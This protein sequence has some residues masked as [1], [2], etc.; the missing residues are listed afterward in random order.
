M[1]DDF[2]FSFNTNNATKD[3]DPFG[4][5]LPPAP[6]AAAAKA[7]PSKASASEDAFTPVVRFAPS[8][9]K[10]L[11]ALSAAPSSSFMAMATSAKPKK[12]RATPLKATAA[13]AAAAAA[14]TATTTTKGKKTSTSVVATK[15]SNVAG[16]VI[17]RKAAAPVAVAKPE[18]DEDDDDEDDGL[19]A[20]QAHK[21]AKKA[22][23][24]KKTAD[25]GFQVVR[26][27]EDGNFDV[28]GGSEAVG[29]GEAEAEVE[30]GPS[31]KKHRSLTLKE[32]PHQYHA[33]PSD[34]ARHEAPSSSSSS[35]GK[36]RSK[37]GETERRPI[38]A[39]ATTI[40]HK[41]RFSEVE[42]LHPRLTQVLEAPLSEGGMALDATTKVQSSI[43][44]LLIKAR[45]AEEETEEGGE[46]EDEEGEKKKRA[47]KKSKEVAAVG[48]PRSVLMKSQTGSG[49]TLAFLLP[50]IHDLMSMQ[51]VPA[52][53]GGTRALVLSPTREL[54][55]QICQVAER[56]TNKCACGLVT[57]T[58]TGGERRKA[59]KARLRKGVVILTA[60]PGRLLDHL[61]STEAFTLSSLRWVVLDEAD[62]LLD[63]G[64]EKAI[65][66]ILGIL[67]GETLDVS[68]SS[69]AKAAAASYHAKPLLGLE[70]RYRA[71]VATHAKI[72][73]DIGGVCY[74]MASA[75]L[76]QAVCR[77]VKPVMGSASAAATKK[78]ARALKKRK[79]AEAKGE[80]VDAATAA[81]LADDENAFYLVD[82]ERE[83]ARLMAPDDVDS[84]LST[85]NNDGSVSMPMDW[86]S[87]GPMGGAMEA[88]AAGGSA[89]GKK[90][91]KGTS[92]VTGEHVAAPATLVQYTMTVS[93]K[94]RLAALT[95]F[96][97]A[98]A[99]DRSKVMVFMST[100]DSVD[101]HSLLF[102]ETVW[103]LEM[104]P[105]PRDGVD[106][107]K[108]KEED[109]AVGTGASAASGGKKSVGK[110]EAALS[111]ANNPKSSAALK[112]EEIESLEPLDICAS[113]GIL[114]DG[115]PIYRLHGSVPQAM[116]AK[117][118]KEFT[119]ASD[120]VLICTDVAA[121]G[122]DLPR[123]DW[124]V[125]YD[126]PCETSDYIH[127]AGRT[128][129]SGHG[130]SALL[131]LL[132]S[133]ASFAT[134]LH[135]HGMNTHAMRLDDLFAEVAPDIPG[136][137]TFKNSAEMAA[138]ILQRR[139]EV[140][141][142]RNRTLIGC[143]RQA[144]RSFV[145]AYATHSSDT[146]GI[147]KVH[148][149]HLGHV[150][151][152]FALGESPANLH[153]QS[154][155][156]TLGKVAN[157]YFSNT[158]AQERADA[159]RRARQDKF[160]VSRSI[161]GGG[162]ADSGRG[163]DSRGD[164]DRDRGGRGGGGRGGG[165]GG[166]GGGGGGRGGGGGGDGK[167]HSAWGLSDGDGG[168][169]PKHDRVKLRAMGGKRGGPAQRGAPSASGNFRKSDGGYFKKKLRTQTNSEFAA[170]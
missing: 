167:T 36:G 42:G 69:N 46:A 131:F 76:S 75:T 66:E 60:T 134:L 25:P 109:G 27:A 128:A 24:A 158:R 117:T 152:N 161:G 13:A 119:E 21:A 145:R 163:G 85:Q 51:P 89:G 40:F 88:V 77:L 48:V 70:K 91:G 53:D 35:A 62:R 136:A 2:D 73:K 44:P 113:N 155:D 110:I 90:G 87:D 151:K 52:R 18:E 3:E 56:L 168:R 148:S 11:A 112:R 107:K 132:P 34:L 68:A 99:K 6:T 154:A 149:L 102:R 12:V 122:L 118:I 74:I 50:I 45:K 170:S 97:R 59:E 64:F 14:A 37:G 65:L 96:L 81:A 121:R 101:Y 72:S 129:R 49:K 41:Q 39:L 137:Q 33:K 140:T 9:S 165:R 71:Q 19:D 160:A 4:L 135:S 61:R 147:F 125:Q 156:D 139:Y 108:D 104:D 31:K 55:T 115:V 133:E 30:A 93:A 10:S 94:W 83:T 5:G 169:Q 43:L 58:V 16:K 162:G 29:G 38:G 127:R 57:G 20:F 95:C 8:A 47:H 80:S 98:K 82:A 78:R 159:R 54:C 17:K 138:V 123:V 105:N 22:A 157:G 141:A 111:A 142:L 7:P 120:G 67:R 15:A 114:G 130:G 144:F 92:L 150:A 79:L 143:A 23:R 100:C 146:K 106:Q 84:L 26:E 126:P 32:D 124:I 116:R 86:A 1:E 28:V 63:M 164:R 153:E 166:G 103:P